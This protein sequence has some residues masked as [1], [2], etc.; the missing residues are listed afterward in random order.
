M[1]R[2]RWQRRV[3]VGFHRID[4]LLVHVVVVVVIV[5]VSVGSSATAAAKRVGTP[6]G[7][8]RQRRVAKAEQASH[9]GSGLS[10]GRAK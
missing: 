3:W 7:G 5:I 10:G 9:L 8:D 2:L 1:L 6:G 4:H